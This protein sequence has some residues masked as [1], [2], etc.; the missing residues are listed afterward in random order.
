MLTLSSAPPRVIARQ[1]GRADAAAQSTADLQNAMI[2]R[3][4]ADWPD[5]FGPY[6]N[7]RTRRQ[8][9][10]RPR[11]GAARVTERQNRSDTARQ[12][13]ARRVKQARKGLAA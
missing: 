3:V 1:H 2:D 11:S 6:P 8:R 9:P 5:E 10:P 7:R 12:A 4:P 13:R